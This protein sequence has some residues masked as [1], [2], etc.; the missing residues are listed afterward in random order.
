[1]PPQTRA[2]LPSERACVMLMYVRLGCPAVV[3]VNVWSSSEVAEENG[4]GRA[5]ETW[6][7]GRILRVA[8]AC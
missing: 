8:T 4:R 7:P 6:V 2:L 3:S 5:I 1:M